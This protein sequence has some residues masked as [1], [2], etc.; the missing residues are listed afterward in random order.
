MPCG[1]CACF[2]RSEALKKA[3]LVVLP[4]ASAPQPMEASTEGDVEVC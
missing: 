3:E 1:V 4:F 2:D